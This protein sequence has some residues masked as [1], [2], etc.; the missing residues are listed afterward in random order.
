MAEWIRHGTSNADHVGSNPTGGAMTNEEIEKHRCEF[1]L[2]DQ[3]C[4]K[5]KK[6]EGPCYFLSDGGYEPRDGRYLCLECLK[7]LMNYECKAQQL[8]LEQEFGV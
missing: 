4:E 8:Q 5:C 6:N 2:D 7:A 1:D 3:P